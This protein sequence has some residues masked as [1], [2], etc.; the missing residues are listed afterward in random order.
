MFN[1]IAESVSAF[2]NRYC[3]QTKSMIWQA[4]VKVLLTAYNKHYIIL[5]L[6]CIIHTHQC[7]LR[8]RKRAAV[9]DSNE[10]TMRGERRQ[11]Q[12]SAPSWD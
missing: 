8:K 4:L 9:D 12:A 7:I 3:L 2:Q 11:T 5:F 10:R 1:Y 6:I